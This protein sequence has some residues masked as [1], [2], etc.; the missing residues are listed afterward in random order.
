M[1]RYMLVGDQIKG[2]RKT[3]WWQTDGQNGDK[4]AGT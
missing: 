2:C 4:E 3:Q 1:G